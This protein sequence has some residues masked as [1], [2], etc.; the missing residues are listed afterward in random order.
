MQS[1]SSWDVSTN[2]I[3][4]ILPK[5]LNFVETN[6]NKFSNIIGILNSKYMMVDLLKIEIMF[7]LNEPFFDDQ[8]F[9]KI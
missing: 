5:L 7:L 4:T 1:V 6:Y 8:K 2:L 3:H 9:K